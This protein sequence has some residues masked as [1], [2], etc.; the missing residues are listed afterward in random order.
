ML[1]TVA[2]VMYTKNKPNK[3]ADSVLASGGL[4]SRG[5]SDPHNR[6]VSQMKLLAGFYVVCTFV[7]WLTF[8]W[9]RHVIG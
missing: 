7:D 9:G 3:R 1:I 4:S 5:A 2:S 8:F 6:I